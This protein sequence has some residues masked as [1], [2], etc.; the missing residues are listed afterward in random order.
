GAGYGGLIRNEDGYVILAYIGCSKT[1]SVI[2]QELNAIYYGLKGAARVGATKLLVA[3]DSMRPV[4][5]I[6]GEEAPPWYGRNLA[7]VIL[8]LSKDFGH[9]SIKHHFRETNRATDYLAG[10]GCATDFCSRVD[11]EA[12][13]DDLYSCS[14]QSPAYV[15]TGILLEEP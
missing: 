15:P 6:N 8:L 11:G 9:F 14:L 4:N 12:F 13:H 1:N 10:L 7:A 3:S 2:I 5:I